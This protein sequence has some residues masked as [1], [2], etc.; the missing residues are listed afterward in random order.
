MRPCK[1]HA[2][3]RQSC[4]ACRQAAF[5]PDRNLALVALKE[6]WK[7]R[8]DSDRPGDVPV[9]RDGVVY[10]CPMSLT[11]VLEWIEREVEGEVS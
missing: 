2:Y 4:E 6:G 3:R 1:V 7:Y 5:R 9:L 10:V 11:D 8:S